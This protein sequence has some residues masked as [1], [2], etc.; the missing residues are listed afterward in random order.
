MAP[1]SGRGKGNKSKNEKKKKEEKGEKLIPKF[2][3]SMPQ[4]IHQLHFPLSSIL[5]SRSSVVVPS[6][7]D[8]TVITPYETQV[9]LKVQYNTALHFPPFT[10]GINYTKSI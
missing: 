5:T 7:V 1:R 3:S 10:L 8:I 9:L 4:F 2:I 6:V